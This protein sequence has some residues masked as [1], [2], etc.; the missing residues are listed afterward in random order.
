MSKAQEFSRLYRDVQAHVSQALMDISAVKVSSEKGTA[1]L[2]AIKSQLSALKSRFNEEIEYL[3]GHSEWEK[4]T[5]AFF[6]ETNAGK[7]TII[8]SLRII[9]GEQ[10]R[11]ALIRS[12][13]ATAEDLQ[14]VFSRDADQL[15]EALSRR[16]VAFDGE[17]AS[18]GRE[19]AGLVSAVRRDGEATREGFSREADRMIE[20]LNA[21][22]AEFRQRIDG[23][24]TELTV[25]SAVV[26]QENEATRSAFA[27]HAE[28]LAGALTA[29]CG[30]FE[31]EVAGLGTRISDLAAIVREES[32]AA[33]EDDRC[34]ARVRLVIGICAGVV[35]GALGAAVGHILLA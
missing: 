6:G 28:R 25:L 34:R 11:Q 29:R 4:F 23:L 8:E 9:F 27:L 17:V 12:N 5:I 13:R 31:G 22:Y 33:R 21:R 1:H 35:A 15:I 20:A 18:L 26:Q 30:A 7:S 10:N 14:T 16:Y 32:E 24:G 2:D 3:D 19:V